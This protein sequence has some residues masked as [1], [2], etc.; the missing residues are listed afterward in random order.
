MTRGERRKPSQPGAFIPPPESKAKRDRGWEKQRAGSEET[1][2]CMVA[3]RYIPVEI[4]ERINEL[5]R[6]Y[7][8]TRRDEIARLWLQLA[9]DMDQRGEIEYP[10]PEVGPSGKLTFFPEIDEL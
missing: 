8:I 3:F 5:A 6:E 10:E 9:F 2:L 1:G 7:R 4:R